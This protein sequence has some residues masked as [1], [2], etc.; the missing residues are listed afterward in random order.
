MSARAEEAGGSWPP[1]PMMLEPPDEFIKRH[2]LELF[3]SLSNETLYNTDLERF[4]TENGAASA[5][6][7][8][9]LEDEKT[10]FVG[11]LTDWDAEQEKRDGKRQRRDTDPLSKVRANISQRHSWNDVIEELERAQ[12]D[13]DTSKRLG[14][15]WKFFRKVGEKSE[16]IEPFLA[17]IPNGDYTSVICGGIKF[18]LGAC[19][20]ANTARDKVAN[21]ISELPQAISSAIEYSELYRSDQTLQDATRDLYIKILF[22]IEGILLHLTKK[23][24]FEWLKPLFQQGAYGPVDDKIEDVK[25]ASERLEMTLKLCEHKRLDI[26]QHGVEGTRSDVATL[27][28]FLV[29]FFSVQLH[30]NAWY[31]DLQRRNQETGKH[32]NKREYISKGELLRFIQP[33]SLTIHE[34]VS[35]KTTTE[36]VLRAGY[37]MGTDK[38]ARAKWLMVDETNAVGEWFK[39]KHSGAILVNGNSCVEMISPLSFFCAMLIQ[40]LKSLEQIIVLNHLCGLHTLKEGLGNELRGSFGLLKNLTSQLV[41]QWHSDEL[42]CLS[43]EYVSAIK[44]EEQNMSFKHLWRLF[45]TLVQALPPMTPLFIFIDGISYYETE[46][47]APGTEKLLEAIMQLL[48]SDR[49]KAMV[50]V[51]VSSA[52]RAMGIKKLF[53]ENETLW[54]PNTL[55][56]ARLGFADTQFQSAFGQRIATLEESSKGR[57]KAWD[58]ET[59]VTRCIE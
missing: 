13:H 21:L 58:T 37:S 49:T 14:K 39:S 50:K 40:S 44:N 51:F 48:E 5:S 52:H 34:V 27:R 33:A 32:P 54:I 22:A 36:R 6:A 3:P 24:S 41:A 30:N 11:I 42:S 19:A 53:R 47:F 56:G 57:K 18:I 26:I 1:G 46:E 25:K 38:Q 15:M 7:K 9:L 16:V 31:A 55:S 12:N 45:Q 43:E 35:Q 8:K 20:A 29:Q 4:K 23:S 10:R 2:F 59:A 28:N 17:F